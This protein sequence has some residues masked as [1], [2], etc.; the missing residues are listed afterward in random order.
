MGLVGDGEVVE[1]NFWKPI[2]V[3]IE[4]TRVVITPGEKGRVVSL[5]DGSPGKDGYRAMLPWATVLMED[6]EVRCVDA[7]EDYQRL[8]PS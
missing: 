7:G 8:R 1:S 4:D 2:E 3:R 5:H 6:G